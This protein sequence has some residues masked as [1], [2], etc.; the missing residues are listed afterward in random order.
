MTLAACGPKGPASVSGG[1]CHVVRAEIASA[2]GLTT[3]DQRIIDE[4]AEAGFAACPNWARPQPRTPSCEI[5][6]HEIA[7]LR[8]RNPVVKKA[9]KKKG[10][11][12]RAKE[13][14]RF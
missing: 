13:A 1:E 14:I 9:P 5:L 4:N 10:I 3:D 2:C 6:R 11:I 7:E 8:N 12:A